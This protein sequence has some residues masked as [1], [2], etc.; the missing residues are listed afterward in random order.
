MTHPAQ[1]RLALHAGNDLGWIERLRVGMHLRGCAECSARV[2]EFTALRAQLGSAPSELPD[3]I[4]EVEW[5]TLAAEMQAN[6]RLGLEAGQI[7]SR[8]DWQATP[9][10]YAWGTLA[11]CAT[12]VAAVGIGVWSQRPAP[13]SIAVIEQ[14]ADDSLS[15]ASATANGIELTRG[16]QGIGL[17]H[18]GAKNVTVSVS[19]SGEVG[20]RYVDASTGYVVIQNVGSIQ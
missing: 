14:A 4:D 6:I 18:Q 10:R 9:P 19:A 2:H 1:N 13:P 12:V 20:A 16:K 8:P 11:I 17:L 5:S 15:I 7:V 3:S